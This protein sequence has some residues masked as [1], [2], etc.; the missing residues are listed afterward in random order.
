MIRPAIFDDIPDVAA[1][2]TTRSFAGAEEDVRAVRRKL[3]GQFGFSALAS[4]DQVHGNNVAVVRGPGHISACD[5]LVTDHSGLLLMIVSADCAL[6]L[7]ADP[8]AGVVGACHAGWRG[9][10]AGVTANTIAAMT[11]LGAA[12]RRI[13]AYVSP[14]ISAEAFEVGEE[15]AE[16]FADH[17]VIRNSAWPRP[18][19]DLKAE[20]LQQLRTA[21]VAEANIQVDAACTASDTK[22]FYSYRA[23]GGTAGRMIGFIGQY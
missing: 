16:Q 12:P 1:G 13:H 22:R 4:A 2:F 6:V 19:V 5:G 23:E 9:A 7:L 17:V 20:L 8:D 21:G 18:H 10:V 15:V 3:A 14:C 11:S